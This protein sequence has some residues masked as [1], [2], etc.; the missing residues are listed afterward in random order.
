MTRIQERNFEVKILGSA[1]GSRAGDAVPGIANFV[2]LGAGIGCAAYFGEGAETNTRGARSAPLRA[3]CVVPGCALT[4]FSSHNH[5][6]LA[7]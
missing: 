2:W 6:R 7:P 5:N 3:G 1:R 4:A